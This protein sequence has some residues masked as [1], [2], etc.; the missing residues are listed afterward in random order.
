MKLSLFEKIDQAL[1]EQESSLHDEI[2]TD[3]TLLAKP[4][5]IRIFKEFLYYSGIP[6]AQDDRAI[7][8]YIWLKNIGVT[9]D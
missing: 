5:R 8:F 4:D 9:L 7:G 2:K 1:L 3:L 6:N